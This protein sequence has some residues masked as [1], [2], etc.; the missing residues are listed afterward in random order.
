ML[1]F[2]PSPGQIL[3]RAQIVELK[4]NALSPKKNPALEI[5]LNLCNEALR[6][7]DIEKPEFQVLAKELRHQNVAQWDSQDA[8]RRCLI[9]G[10]KEVS[11][12]PFFDLVKRDADGNRNRAEL[13]SKIDE[14]FGLAGERKIY[15]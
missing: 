13:V 15:K 11:F 2:R 14:L 6:M 3:D 8:I 4:I 1:L 9:L 7:W 12:R 5:E 10:H